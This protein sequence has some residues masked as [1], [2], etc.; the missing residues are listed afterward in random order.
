MI[1]DTSAQDHIVGAQKNNTKRWLTMATIAFVVIVAI[2]FTFNRFIDTTPEVNL[3]RLRIA[4]VK[5]GHLVRDVSVNG[6]VVAGFSPVLY[7]SNSGIVSF[8]VK[9]GEQVKKDQIVAIIE[10]PELQNQLQ[11]EQAILDRLSI[12]VKRQT[13]ENQKNDLIA[14][15][16]LEEAR[17]TLLTAKR[18]K[19]R[20]E[21]AWEKGA[22][23]EVDYQKS[24]DELTSAEIAYAHAL[25][26]A[27]L[28]VA[29]WKFEQKVRELELRQQELLVADLAR[30]VEALNIVSPIDGMVG[31]LMVDEKAVIASNAGILSVV[32]LTQLE[33]EAQ[34]P[35]IYA[36]ALS[37]GLDSIIRMGNSQVRGHLASISPQ[38]DDGLVAARIR[39]DEELPQELRQNQRLQARVLLES[40]DNTLVLTRGPFMNDGGGRIAYLVAGNYAERLSIKTGISNV[41]EIEI[42][43]GLNPGDKV[44]ISSIELFN[45]ADRVRLN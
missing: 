1:K 41:A 6:K 29:S 11:Q 4:E 42:L 37:T 39:F 28:N 43:E 34:I 15:K 32:D 9:A 40:R 25:E 26:E 8:N 20:N 10:S 31:N 22:V 35:E 12:E 5:T 23:T 38:V 45:N 36:D 30:K 44:V 17:R 2:G 24:K 16:E 7:S 18:E 21:K 13:I 27:D 14:R 33:L 19:K 3:D